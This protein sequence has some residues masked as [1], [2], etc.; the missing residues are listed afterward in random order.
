LRKVDESKKSERG[1]DVFP[2]LTTQFIKD[3]FI[4]KEN[5]IGWQLLYVAQG[6]KFGIIPNGFH[7][8]LYFSADT[9]QL[10]LVVQN[11]PLRLLTHLSEGMS[12]RF[13]KIG[14]G[15]DSAITFAEK[16]RLLISEF[17]LKPQL[18]IAGESFAGFLAQIIAFSVQFCSIESDK[19][20]FSIEQGVMLTPRV[21]IF[22]SPSAELMI[23]RCA[24]NSDDAYTKLD[25]KNCTSSNASSV[26]ESTS[27]V[28]QPV[29]EDEPEDGLN[30]V[31]VSVGASGMQSYPCNPPQSISQTR[32]LLEKREDLPPAEKVK[33]DN[34]TGEN[35]STMGNHVISEKS[36]PKV[37]ALFT[38]CLKVCIAILKL[39]I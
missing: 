34:T 8:K 29:D 4:T 39:D 16:V 28:I 30:V 5:V 9:K 32:F 1:V 15:I 37:R 21:Y 23:S 27:L 22:D 31:I 33:K 36:I 11:E 13:L 19:V 12:R 35:S 10:M 24:R 6:K 20:W 3:N 2:K 25:I 26:E 7:G 14:G 38:T 17:E 18:C